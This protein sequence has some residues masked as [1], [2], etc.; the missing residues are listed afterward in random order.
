MVD[1]NPNA[2]ATTED[3]IWNFIQG[4]SVKTLTFTQTD[5]WGNKIPMPV[6]TFYE[7]DLKSA[8]TRRQQT[9][10]ETNLPQTFP[11]G[12]PKWNLIL[13]LSTAY[14]D[15]SDPDDDGTRRIYLNRFGIT[16]LQQ[17]MQRKGIKKFGAGTHVRWTLVGFKPNGG[18]YQPS[19]LQEIEL[20]NPTEPLNAN[21]Q[22]TQAMVQAG[23]DG[24]P[25]QTFS[26]PPAQVQQVVAAPQQPTGA[27]PPAAAQQPAQAPAQQ[28]V[29]VPVDQAALNAQAAALLAQQAAPAVAPAG[30]APEV[31]ARL[32]DGAGKLAAVGFTREQIVG[33]LAA[34]PEN[35]GIT[36]QQIDDAI[37]V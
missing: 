22:A 19:K 12:N 17:E 33:A 35:A 1:M 18:N 26:A 11:D 14:R 8:P 30:L 23:P 6:G 27:M 2:A 29:A 36:G 10:P 34:M 15:A 9:D 3:D 25:V 37:P 31:E 7:G 16:A 21:Q 20:T 32:Q 13:E 28:P 4:G 24:K 5:Q